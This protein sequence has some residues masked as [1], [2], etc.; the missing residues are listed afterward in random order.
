LDTVAERGIPKT[1]DIL[2]IGFGTTVAMW[3]VGYICRL[4]AVQAPSWLL[5]LLL[6]GCLL[7]GGF[8]AGR[9]SSR[10]VRAGAYTGALAALLNLLILGSL[11]GGHEPNAIT[12]T[13]L[14]WIPGSFLVA[15]VLATIGAALGGFTRQAPV[16]EMNWPASFARVGVVATFFLLIVGGL[17][18]SNRAG[19]A[20][21]DWPNSFGYNMFLYPLSRMSGGIY[22]E[23]AH[24]LF[25]SLV[26]LTM[27]V[28]VIYL[29][30]VEPRRWLRVFALLAF[31]AV[32]AQGILGG[33]RVTGTF[34]TSQSPEETSPSLALAVVHGVLGQIIFAM[35]VSIAV[36]TSTTWR[37]D[38]AASR[39]AS[40]ATDRSISVF[41]LGVLLV[42][43]V[44]GAIQRHLAGGLLI[45]IAMAV[46]VLLVGLTAGVRAWGIYVE[47][48]L[49]QRIGK[50]LVVAVVLQILLG[51]GA[52]IGR[53]LE[54]GTEQLPAVSVALRTAHQAMG[55]VLLA[56]STMLALWI[57]RLI[58][59]LT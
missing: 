50:I 32:V 5:L 2:V 7:L 17:V 3:A 8:F 28:F 38:Q 51:I 45:H 52:L 34:T 16:T 24:R 35:L 25:G 55:A 29:Q 59:P 41:L 54:S 4:P 6:L 53:G 22:Y 36:F 58:H 44:L 30:R 42:Q 11:L 47:Q 56:L 21:V 20:V 9:I 43:L 19:L 31:L 27:L 10:G 48:P 14:W 46:F 12:P 39:S 15:I 18:T 49:V 33:L 57:R 26:G 1:S 13:A 40:A 23:H 37:G